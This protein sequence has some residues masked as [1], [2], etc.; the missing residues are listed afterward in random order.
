MNLESG[1][2]RRV[3]ASGTYEGRESSQ[4]GFYQRVVSFTRRGEDVNFARISFTWI[5]FMSPFGRYFKITFKARTGI[6][7]SKSDWHFRL[8]GGGES[9]LSKS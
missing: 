7:L 4:G 8:M 6:A 3:I 1:V 9:L 5:L 2:R